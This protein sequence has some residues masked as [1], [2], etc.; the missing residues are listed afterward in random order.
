VP[1]V[2]YQIY[3]TLINEYIRYA[4][5]QSEE[6]KARLINRINRIP[7]YDLETLNKFKKGVSFEDAVLKNRL[8][9]FDENIVKQA[10]KLLPQ[11]YISQKLI[12]FNHRDIL[13]YGYADVVGQNRIIDIK[14]TAKYYEE[15]YANSAQN[16]YLYGLRNLGFTQMEYHI[17]DFEKIHVETYEIS[18]YDFEPLLKQIENFALFLE[19]NRQ[20]IKDKKIF[21]EPNFDLFS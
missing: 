16:L 10:K 21:V 1:D 19:E 18:T 17:F 15:K 13:F 3:P 4:K 5:N 7:D 9:N 2:K 12:K 20:I 6:E 11:P 8:H 14:T